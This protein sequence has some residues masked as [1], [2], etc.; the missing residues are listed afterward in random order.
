MR[1]RKLIQLTVILVLALIL[2][3]PSEAAD[4]LIVRQNLDLAQIHI[5]S[6]TGGQWK[7]GSTMPITFTVP[8][9]TGHLVTISVLKGNDIFYKFPHVAIHP[10]L[11][12]KFSW[13]IPKDCPL[14]GNYRIQ[15]VSDGNALIRG[16]SGPFDIVS[17]TAGIPS[18]SQTAV[19]R[20]DISLSSKTI[21]VTSPTANN[22]WVVPSD[23]SVTVKWVHA[24]TSTVSTVNIKLLRGDGTLVKPLATG[25][26]F[27]QGSYSWKLTGSTVLPGEYIMQVTDA[28]SVN[29]EGKSQ[30][31]TLEAPTISITSPVNNDIWI[32]GTIRKV[33]WTYTGSDNQIVKVMEGT[34]VAAEV[35][36][37][38][39]NIGPGKGGADVK[40]ADWDGL[41]IVTADGKVSSNLVK[42][43]LTPP[44]LKVTSPYAG[45]LWYYNHPHTI[46]WSYNGNPEDRVEVMLNYL[47]SPAD[48]YHVYSFCAPAKAGSCAVSHDLED[49]LEAH[50]YAAKSESIQVEIRVRTP[51]AEDIVSY[52]T[53]RKK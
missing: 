48:S 6:P 33:Q 23:Q 29:T 13:T 3:S 42:V 34:K 43:F 4:N 52:V 11:E 41:Q 7:A 30:P 37:N 28:T 22:T 12:T 47:S 5:S 49:N 18:I 45:Q 39:G 26:P 31:F 51:F 14:G 32:N 20:T 35:P 50:L 10:A 24:A 38:A 36:I 27:S 16:N 1:V 8:E 9:G 15:I 17:S 46:S 44:A 19:P 53:F 40:L 2:G 25:I 21:V